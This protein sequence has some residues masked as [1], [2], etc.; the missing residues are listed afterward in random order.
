MHSVLSTAICKQMSINTCAFLIHQSP[1]FLSI[2][3]NYFHIDN[4]VDNNDKSL[5]ALNILGLF[6]NNVVEVTLSHWPSDSKHIMLLN[7]SAS[8]AL[9]SWLVNGL[10]MR[11][12]SAIECHFDAWL[13][14]YQSIDAAFVR[15]RLS[16][17]HVPDVKSP[18]SIDVWLFSD[19]KNYQISTFYNW[20]GIVDWNR[21]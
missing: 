5:C 19:E 2:S 18:Q 8:G 20:F 17:P 1:R 6:A 10:I 11:D 7:N 21:R 15:V 16:G 12:C 3:P 4:N 13:C 14:W 9:T